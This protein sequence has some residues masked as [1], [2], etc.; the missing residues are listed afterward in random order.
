MVVWLSKMWH[1]AIHEEQ[2]CSR[3][4]CRRGGL[5]AVVDDCAIGACPS[6]GGE[7][8]LDEPFLLLPPPG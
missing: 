6:D 8:G 5:S 7:A 4:G 3:D 1:T 2:G